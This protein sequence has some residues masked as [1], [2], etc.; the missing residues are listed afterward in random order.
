ME[1]I[2]MVKD[3]EL[4]SFLQSTKEEDALKKRITHLSKIEQF[5]ARKAVDA[6]K[7]MTEIMNEIKKIRNGKRDKKESKESQNAEA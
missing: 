7:R 6:R 3:E 4:S 1:A 5:H 2:E